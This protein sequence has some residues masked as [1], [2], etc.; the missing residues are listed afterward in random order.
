MV[1]ESLIEGIIRSFRKNAGWATVIIG[2]SVVFAVFLNRYIPTVYQSESLLRVMTTEAG[3]D[4]SIAASMQGLLA[5]KA[6]IAQIAQKSGL[7]ET[8][9]RRDDVISLVDHG[10]GLVMLTVRHENPVLLKE[11]GNAIIDVLSE[12]F[13]GYNSEA[14]EFE[15]KA[16]KK[17]LTHLETS[18]NEIKQEIVAQKSISV[19]K[20]DDSTLV[21]ENLAHQLEEK[22]DVNG[23]R[24][25]TVPKEVFYYQE[26]ETPAYRKLNSQLSAERNELAELFKS[27]KEKHP[28]VIACQNRIK[29]LEGSLKK[30]RTRIQKSKSNSEYVALS[31]EIA[32]DRE[33]LEQVKSELAKQARNKPVNGDG[34]EDT[35]ETL[36]LRIK[37]LEELHRKT[38]MALEES[39]IA[40]NTSAGRI[41]VLKKD[42]RPPQAVG[43]TSFQRDAM[44]LASGVLLA[45]FLLYSP[46]PVR[47]ELVSVSGNILAGAVNTENRPSLLAEPA[48]I[49][50]EVPSLISEPLALPC[51][52]STDICETIFD[53]R[54]IALND[55]DSTRL[56]P[57]KSL[58]SN[59]QISI[60]ES[61]T[62]IVL[63][64]SSRTG[65]GRTTLLAN[66]AILLARAGYSVLM[67]DA[68]FRKPE[69]HR[70][71]DLTNERGLS[72]AL[73][74]TDPRLLIKET[75]VERL[76]L[77][78]A[79]IVPANPAEALGSQE[80]IELLA[81]LRRRVEIIL[82][83]TPALL[84]YPEAGI[85]AGHTGAM[86]FLHREGEPEEDLH[87]S[88]K[89]LKNV[90]ARVFG[91]VKI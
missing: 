34:N 39:K 73:R 70:L 4:V 24:L 48:E 60:S 2:L 10:P 59:L 38:M 22:I 7:N 27:Y 25:Q 30:S 43:F 18:I 68:N 15:I 77:L 3:H 14:Q 47:A 81:N 78:S 45:I 80:M 52:S 53:E 56:K 13:L 1:Q 90:R 65:A 17:K 88:R 55:P 44:A 69:L 76:S 86:V 33:K 12:H 19:A 85:M 72:E 64:G 57:F 40:H 83:D 32:S 87:A 71:F 26:E 5:Q 41:N 16:L 37:T 31:A 49:I 29:E 89:L 11:L 20:V 91:Y 23:R 74:G 84:E 42:A 63:V 58:V 54:L 36:A 28:R 61:Q 66:T 82:I 9:I 79:G 62:R 50:L 35:G 51:P 21:L 46:A 67:V 75:A 8:E 6:V